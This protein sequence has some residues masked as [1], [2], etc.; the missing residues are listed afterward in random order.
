MG[1]AIVASDLDQIGRLLTHKE[2]AILVPPGNANKLAEA[3]LSLAEDSALRT[4]IGS[5]A[6]IVAMNKYSWDSHVC[7]ILDYVIGNQE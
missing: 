6:R 3:I 2:N 7:S 1:K 5:Q 4:R